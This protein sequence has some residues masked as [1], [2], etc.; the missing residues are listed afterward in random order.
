MTPILTRL[1]KLCATLAGLILVFITAL[2]VVS[3][4]GRDVWGSAIT[5][6]FELVAVATGAAVA[7]F[8]PWCQ[9][10]RAH[11]TVDFFTQRASPTAQAALDR[12]GAVLMAVFMA[13]MA[14]RTTLGA[15]NAW[16]TQSG[17]MMMGWPDWVTFA[18]IAPPLA[19]AAVIAGVQGLLGLGALDPDAP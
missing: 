2:T 9:L 15:H 6:D 14:W 8:M 13:V 11:I 19:L 12:A 16:A 7:L 17:T 18:L 3:V 4:L 5:G 10:K 1:A